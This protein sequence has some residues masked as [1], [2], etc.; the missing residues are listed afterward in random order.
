MSDS[1]PLGSAT[2]EN[3]KSG[4]AAPSSSQSDAATSHNMM[5]HDRTSNRTPPGHK[6]PNT[7]VPD[8]TLSLQT[9]STP[10]ISTNKSLHNLGPD[11]I[12]AGSPKSD[13]V[14][15]NLISPQQRRRKPV[16]TRKLWIPDQPGAWAMVLIPIVGGILIGGI[17]WRNI[18]LFAAWILCYCFQF[19]A[20]RWLVSHGARRFL[21]PALTYAICLVLVGLPLLIANPALLWWTPLYVIVA[22]VSLYAASRRSERSL[23]ANAADVIG[24]SAMCTIAVQFGSQY[25]S[26]S[27]HS[28]SSMKNPVK[29]LMRIQLNSSLNA[30][31]QAGIVA[32]LAFAAWGYGSVLFVKSMI[33]RYGSASY[34]WLSVIWHISLAISGFMMT[35]SWGLVS[36]VLLLR[37]AGL[38]KIGHRLKPKHIGIV[39]M[40]A[41]LLALGAITIFSMRL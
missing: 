5:P 13:S 41:S 40:V 10:T 37:A 4:F 36:S 23:W 17:S 38:P 33:R 7:M 39:E 24:A 6:T 20:S 32:G 15:A 9:E 29:T 18:W 31:P 12:P 14:G 22:A 30:L 3:S 25:Y 11:H 21:G 2:A 35:P 28:S 27:F 16:H 34:Y 26:Q 8:R 19:T 1:T